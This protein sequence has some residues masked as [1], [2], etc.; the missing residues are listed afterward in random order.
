MDSAK[1]KPLITY[2][3]TANDGSRKEFSGRI[4]SD[5]YEQAFEWAKPSGLY[6]FHPIGQGG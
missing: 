3:A 5:T 1:E 4:Y 6:L 2:R